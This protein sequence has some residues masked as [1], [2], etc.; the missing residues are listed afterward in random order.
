VVS[1]AARALRAVS[2]ERL[3]GP[4][5]GKEMRVTSRRRRHFVLRAAYVACLTLWTA[6]VWASSVG[7][8]WGGSSLEQAA[9]M[10]AAGQRVVASILWF[11]FAAAQALA[12]LLLAR[13]IPT[14]IT[15]G[16]L[17]TLAGT[18][19][20]SRQIVWGKLLGRLL[21]VILLLAVSLPLL[22]VVRV[23]GGVPW[24]PIVAG[25]A[26]TLASA[27]LVGAFSLF[28]STRGK[29]LLS[30]IILT[31]LSYLG[32]TAIGA[33]TGLQPGVSLVIFAALGLTLI[34]VPKTAWGRL[35]V[36]AILVLVGCG[37]AAS[38]GTGIPVAPVGS[39]FA[40][41][42]IVE[43][44]SSISSA[45]I[46]VTTAANCAV[47]LLGA[48]FLLRAAGRKVRELSRQPATQGA[49][50][51][52]SF[53]RRILGIGAPRQ[54]SRV[55][56][57]ALIWKDLRTFLPTSRRQAY[58]GCGLALGVLLLSYMPLVGLRFGD[59]SYL[60]EFYVFLYLVAAM[61]VTV[62]A[63]STALTVEKESRALPILL[64]APL[65]DTQLLFSKAVGVFYR[66]A[67]PGALL[68]LHLLIFT[69]ALQ[70]HPACAAAVILI[71]AG[72]GVF[73]TGLGL[74]V[75][76]HVRSSAT[77]VTIAFGVCVAL[78][79]AA[80]I[81]T[82][83]LPREIGEVSTPLVYA[84]NPFTEIHL[85]CLATQDEYGGVLGTRTLEVEWR[86][87]KIPAARAMAIVLAATVGY[88][89]AGLALAARAK[90]LMR[91]RLF[92]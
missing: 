86:R 12:L 80:P 5:L 27:L 59:T 68:L 21:E 78:W 29:S 30:T 35:M 34:F 45:S 55:K 40:L 91:R 63:S 92:A 87:I 23:F 22:A 90:V 10:A 25:L 82:E 39:V 28:L 24:G 61:F 76:S 36:I 69:L 46:A 43:P 70:I 11:Q 77:A 64:T 32:L 15:R 62:L 66:A 31:A 54:A 16:T 49:V 74:Y 60:H 18:P 84:A 6:L 67:A 51:L 8:G 17:G 2:P 83:T 7:D 9:Y 48:V 20:S 44:S 65:S 19:I 4:V 14:E 47:M 52:S 33:I 26:I 88:A 73:L 75:S 57:P 50:S 13:E 3:T 53:R 1:A 56:G 81:V 71:G 38:S 42:C 37:W 41:I 89:L 58:L 85:A 79:G 72:Q